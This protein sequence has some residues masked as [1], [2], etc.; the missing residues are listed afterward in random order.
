LESRPTCPP[1]RYRL[2]QLGEQ[3]ISEANL[4]SK[5]VQAVPRRAGQPALQAGTDCTNLASRPLP[6][7][8]GSPSWYRLYHLGEQ[9]NLLS[10]PVQ[11]VSARRAGQPAFQAGTDC[12]SSAS[13]LTCSPSRY[14]LYQLGKQANLLAELVQTVLAWQAGKPTRREGR[15][16]TGSASRQV[17]LPS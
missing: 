6:R 3:T 12:I 11:T 4:L 2:H 14:R 15:F 13:R 8:I 10:K 16:T 7:P 5:L 9:A 17:C 1:S